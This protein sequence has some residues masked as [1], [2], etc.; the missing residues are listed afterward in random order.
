MGK[1]LTLIDA[2]WASARDRA[3]AGRKSEAR[4]ILVTLLGREDLPTALA[5][6]A[7]R[8]AAKLYADGERYAKARKHLK[9]A[10]TLEPGN[11]DTHYQLAAAY[12]DDA[13]GCDLRA[14][15][16]YRR[17]VARDGT[18]ALYHAAYGRALVRAA[19]DRPAV[20]AL[21]EA[22][23]LAPTDAKVLAVVVEAYREMNAARLAWDVVCKAKFL[24]PADKA[25]AAMWQRAKFDLA[26]EGQSPRMRKVL[27]FV[28]LVGTD[29]ESRAVR[30]DVGSASAP[31]VYRLHV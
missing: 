8:L 23:E 20:R 14:A 9:A 27:P 13:Y 21:R 25:I 24:A 30:R 7:H 19:K 10:R 5:A 26:S 6:K 17:A 22:V 1:T 28:R 15:K 18:N 4:G 3:Q 12:A 31:H 2:A 11:A 29:G 16:S